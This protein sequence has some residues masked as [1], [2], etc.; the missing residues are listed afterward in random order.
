MYCVITKENLFTMVNLHLSGF[1]VNPTLVRIIILKFTNPETMSEVRSYLPSLFLNLIPIIP[2]FLILLTVCSTITLSLEC[3]LLCFFSSSE[4]SLFFLFFLNGGHRLYSGK[5]ILNAHI[6]KVKDILN[7]ERSYRMFIFENFIIMYSSPIMTCF[8]QY[9]TFTVYHV[10]C[11]DSMFLLFARVVT[12]S[13]P[14]V[15]WPWDSLF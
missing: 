1:R 3:F 15:L 10:L 8:V 7:L 5:I 9:Q 11:L 14:F 13:S 6:S 12:L 4:S 2:Y